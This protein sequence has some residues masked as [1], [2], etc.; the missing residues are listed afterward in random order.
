[1]TRLLIQRAFAIGCICLVATCSQASDTPQV[2]SA[3]DS[4]VGVRE[5]PLRCGPIAVGAGAG[6]RSDLGARSLL[7]ALQDGGP[8]RL[9][10]R[11]AS[12]IALDTL[13]L[14]C[15]GET[16][17]AGVFSPVDSVRR[18]GHLLFE[19]HRRREDGWAPILE[20]SLSQLT[21][22]WLAADLSRSGRRDLVLWERD[23]SAFR[24]LVYGWKGE[25]YQLLKLPNDY[26]II[27]Y[28]WTEGYHPECITRLM[29]RL[30]GQDTLLLLRSIPPL[31]PQQ[32]GGCEHMPTD[33]L[34]VMGDSLRRAAIHP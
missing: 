33:T 28:D 25:A 11:V 1:M 34:V 20:L 9:T 3:V 12:W 30:I 32:R 10:A 5:K 26:T 4:S 27:N 22:L 19:A 8:P 17:I 14:D 6:Q 29:P 24:P 2:N 21:T 15:D 23:E 18:E 7:V 13:D 16:D 31:Q